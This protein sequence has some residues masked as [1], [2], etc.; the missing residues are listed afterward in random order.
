[1]STKPHSTRKHDH[2]S[3]E[4]IFKR[5]KRAVEKDGL[6]QEL[7]GREFFEKPSMVRKRAKAAAVKRNQRR[8]QEER[9]KMN[10][11]RI[12]QSKK[13]EQKKNQRGKDE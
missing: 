7:R 1:M 12:L 4:A 2:E 8:V 9:N 6:I 3:F 10:P 5:W 11:K 13:R